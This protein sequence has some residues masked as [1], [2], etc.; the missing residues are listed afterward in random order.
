MRYYSYETDDCF[1]YWTYDKELY[2][3][4]R[5]YRDEYEWYIDA[6]EAYGMEPECYED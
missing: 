2:S 6:C 5:P 4:S 3:S 1:A